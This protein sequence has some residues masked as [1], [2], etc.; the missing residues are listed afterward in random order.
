MRLSL[1]STDVWSMINS[2][3]TESGGGRWWCSVSSQR[4]KVRGDSLE[5]YV[6]V[7][8]Q[9]VAVMQQVKILP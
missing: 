6:D 3:D 5:G 4:L 8:G 7:G 1:I 2:L 9:H